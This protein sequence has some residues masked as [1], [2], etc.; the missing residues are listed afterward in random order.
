M[1]G[2]IES[3]L[4]GMFFVFVLIFIV[5]FWDLIVPPLKDFAM[6]FLSGIG[7]SIAIILGVVLGLVL[8]C[9]IIYKF[10][11]FVERS[12]KSDKRYD[13]Y[14]ESINNILSKFN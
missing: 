2:F 9:V 14:N 7:K 8:L 3:I 5:P 13:E 4:I 6:L 11:K 12:K 10:V 1:L